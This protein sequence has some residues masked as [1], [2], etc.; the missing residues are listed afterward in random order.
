MHYQEPRGP[1][2]FARAAAPARG[3]L[4]AGAPGTSPAFT[5]LPPSPRLSTLRILL[6]GPSALRCSNF[7]RSPW[8]SKR[9]LEP[10]RGRVG[11]GRHGSQ[12]AEEGLEE[13]ALEPPFPGGPARSYQL[14]WSAGC[15]WLALAPGVGCC[16][17]FMAVIARGRV[18]AHFLAR[19]SDLGTITWQGSQVTGAQSSPNGR[20]GERQRRGGGRGAQGGEEARHQGGSP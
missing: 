2:S 11:R 6:P 1:H 12:A 4:Q 18:C 7:L 20:K 5:S 14:T 8:R 9:S 16:S 13:R 19:T 10:G 3:G 17:C 15:A